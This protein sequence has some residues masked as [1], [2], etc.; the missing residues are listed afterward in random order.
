MLSSI[1]W[2]DTEGNALAGLEMI[3]II[4]KLFPEDYAFAESLIYGDVMYA[5]DYIS[6]M[7]TICEKTKAAKSIIDIEATLAS[8]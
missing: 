2:K 3:G 4:N 6:M 7:K 1:G 8:M 5:D